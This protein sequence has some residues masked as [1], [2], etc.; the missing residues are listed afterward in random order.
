M[1]TLTS[2]SREVR[3]F[4]LA[5]REVRRFSAAPS[6]PRPFDFALEARA[7]EAPLCPGVYFYRVDTTRGTRHGRFV[8]LR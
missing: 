5:G 1:V 8:V 6:G 4:D 7:S 3:V 2:S